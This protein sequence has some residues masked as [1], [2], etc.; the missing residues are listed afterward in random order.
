MESFEIDENSVAP[1]AWYLQQKIDIA[2]KKL[3][4]YNPSHLTVRELTSGHLNKPYL[5]ALTKITLGD[6]KHNVRARHGEVCAGVQAQV[7]C[8][9]DMA[10]DPDLLGRTWVGWSSW[11]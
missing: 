8:L 1:P 6:K 4:G 10:T 7:E 2:R 5:P 3:E 11:I 9:I